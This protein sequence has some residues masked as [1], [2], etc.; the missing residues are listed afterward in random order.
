MNLMTLFRVT[1]YFEEYFYLSIMP[2]Y[3]YDSKYL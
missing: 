3:E 1:H 2:V